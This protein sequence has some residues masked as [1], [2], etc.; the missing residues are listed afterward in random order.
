MKLPT[1]KKRNKGTY[2]D[3]IQIYVYPED[4]PVY[5]EASAILKREGSSIS[6][7]CRKT[8]LDYA[9]LHAP[10]NP[11]QSMDQILLTSK[12]YHA[13]ATCGFRKCGK[14]AVGSG[15]HVDDNKKEKD[16]YLCENH[17]SNVQSDRRYW[18][19]VKRFPK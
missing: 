9:K 6:E 3:K 13:G 15:T 18:K 19:N 10:G 4:K 16:Y 5:K 11:Q 8:I 12:P 1:V 7:L 17:F 2:K 14:P